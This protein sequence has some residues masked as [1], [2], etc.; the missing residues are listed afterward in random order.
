MME[1]KRIAPTINGRVEEHH[2]D[3]LE[4]VDPLLAVVT[5]KSVLCMLVWSILSSSV[6]SKFVV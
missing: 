2:R 6:Q 5:S 4:I 3:Y 1:N